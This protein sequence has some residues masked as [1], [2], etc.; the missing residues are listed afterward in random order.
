MAL[1]RHRA[2]AQTTRR[3]SLSYRNL[4][5]SLAFSFHPFLGW[6]C[7][8]VLS[9]VAA[10]RTL[11]AIFRGCLMSRKRLNAGGRISRFNKPISYR[12]SVTWAAPLS[13]RARGGQNNERLPFVPPEDW[14]E[15]RED[16]RAYRIIV[17]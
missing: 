7:R 12:R 5:C 15:P 3:K 10:G 13:N 2:A 16:G 4:R 9:E 11:P 8:R 6:K 1:A 17:Q 14:H